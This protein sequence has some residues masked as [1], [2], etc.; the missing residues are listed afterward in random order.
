MIR[1]HLAGELTVGAY[2]LLLDET[3]CFL[4][5]DF[6]KKTWQEDAAAFLGTC[7]E[8]NVPAALERSRSGNGGHVWIFF[9]RAIPAVTARKLGCAILTRTMER[10]HQVGLEEAI[11]SLNPK[12]IGLIDMQGDETEIIE[13]VCQY[14][15]GLRDETPY[16]T[17]ADG[18]SVAGAWMPVFSVQG[19]E[20]LLT[21]WFVYADG[22]ARV[23]AD[24]PIVPMEETIQRFEDGNI[25][26]SIDSGT[27][28]NIEGLGRFRAENLRFHV[29]GSERIREARNRIVI[30]QGGIG[31]V[32]ECRNRYREYEQNPTDEA[33]ERLRQAYE[34]V[35]KHMQ[36]FC[37]DMDSKDWPIRR[38][39][40][41]EPEGD[42]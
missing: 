13:G 21:Q 36:R 6:D 1:Q 10:R 20:R 11:D 17:K 3:C 38:I 18:T 7:Q 27:W 9:D 40:Y 12:R 5:V 16:Y 14:K 4:A 24:G 29:A 22:S 15:I 39:L 34:A 26:T 23:G 30:L 32:Q 8:L 41:G 33:R 35:P 37:G 25:V 19:T 42:G 2:P 31:A 28:V